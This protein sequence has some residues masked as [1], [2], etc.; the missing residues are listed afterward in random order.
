MIQTT[1]MRLGIQNWA[2]EHPTYT[3]VAEMAMDGIAYTVAITGIISTAAT[4]VSTA[5]VSIPLAVVGI[6][7]TLTQKQIIKKKENRCW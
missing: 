3:N 7:S 2:N 6:S 5:K 1:E 4:F